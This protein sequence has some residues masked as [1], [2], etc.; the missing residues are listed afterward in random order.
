MSK[1]SLVRLTDRGWK[2]LASAL[3]VAS[4]GVFLLDPVLIVISIVLFYLVGVAYYQVHRTLRELPKYLKFSPQRLESTLTA[5]EELL[6]PLIVKYKYTVPVEIES[7]LKNGSFESTNI[8]TGEST[9]NFRFR[10]IYSG[11]FSSTHVKANLYDG[12]GL[13]MGES[14][15]PLELT[16]KVFPRTLRAAEEA[17]TFILSSTIFSMG[18][19]PT[20]LRGSGFE[21]AD[22]RQYLE[23][24][25]LRRLDW[26]ATARLGKLMI[27]EYFLEGGVGW[28]VIFDSASSDPESKDELTAGFLRTVLAIARQGSTLKVTVKEGGEITTYQTL[29]PVQAVATALEASL[30]TATVSEGDFYGLLE[31]RSSSRLRAILKKIKADTSSQSVAYHSASSTD[32]FNQLQKSMGREE[33]G[34]VVL[35]SALLEDPVEILNLSSITK[36]HD[37]SIS[38]LQPTRPW[39]WSLDLSSSNKNRNRYIQVYRVLSREGIPVFASVEDM[40]QSLSSTTYRPAISLWKQ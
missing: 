9:I 2:L 3:A 8:P 24:D 11:T 40:M 6:E 17:A 36:M 21:Y 5:G 28:H 15:I 38:I 34:A 39:I 13:A 23:G 7:P 10:S 32:S 16:F 29:D 22:T 12:F 18:E 35:V 4:F 26:K 31:P 37:S 27:K 33:K 25:S 1:D 30:K 20:E 14:S 19:D